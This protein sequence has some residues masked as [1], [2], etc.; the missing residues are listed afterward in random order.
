M[1]VAFTYVYIL[2][3]NDDPTRHYTGITRDLKKRLAKHNKG[4]CPH[5]A[6]Y[7]PWRIDTAIAFSTR[8]KAIAFERYLKSHSGRAFAAKHF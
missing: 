8:E 3:N 4:D 7:R 1:N 6:K 2:A 5:T